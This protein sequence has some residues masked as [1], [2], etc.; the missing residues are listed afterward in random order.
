MERMAVSRTQFLK[1]TLLPGILPRIWRVFATGFTQVPYFIAVIYQ[2]VGILPRGHAYLDPRNVG[3]YGIRHVIAEAANHLV[4]DRKH[5]DQVFIFFI[6]LVGAVLLF[7]QLILLITAVIAYQPV[8]AAAPAL[9]DLTGELIF[10]SGPSA[11][12]SGPK[13]DLAFIFLDRVF[14]IKG[15]FNSCVDP[16]NGFCKSLS[17][18]DLAVFGTFPS[19]FHKALHALLRFYSIGIFSIASFLIIYFIIAI[20]GETAAAGRAF[21]PPQRFNRVWA[22]V[23]LILCFA[24]LI[25]LESCEKSPTTVGLNGAQYITLESAKLGSNFATNGWNYFTL[26]LTQTH[27]GDAGKLI[28]TPNTPKVNNLLKFMFLTRVCKSAENFAYSGPFETPNHGPDGIQAYIVSGNQ[29]M[30]LATGVSFSAARTFSKNGNIFIRFGV[31]NAQMY[32]SEN[33]NV[34]PLCGEIVVPVTKIDALGAPTSGAS[35]IQELYFQMVRDLWEKDDEMGKYANCMRGRNSQIIPNP[36]CTEIPDQAFMNRRITYYQAKLDKDIKDAI[37]KQVAAGGWNIDP[38]MM[39]KGW[40]GAG[41]WYNRIAELNGD[42]SSSVYSIPVSSKYP[43]IMEYVAQQRQKNNQ[44]VSVSTIYTP[45]LAQGREITPPR[46]AKDLEIAAILNKTYLLW[47]V[48]NPQAG[49]DPEENYGSFIDTVNTIFGTSGLFSMRKNTDIH[50]LAQ[51][52]VLGK[53]MMYASI[54]NFTGGKML[55]EIGVILDKDGPGRALGEM[56]GSFFVTMGMATMA[57]SFVL[58]Y[59]IPFMPF[60]YFIF[61]VGAWVK[62]IFEAMV[63]M[64]LW[65]L[66]HIRIDGEGMPGQAATQG[67]FLILEI[68]LRPILIV[69]GLLASI[70]VFSAL[71]A[72]MN[73]IF[74]L[75]TA[76]LGGF[77]K[78]SEEAAIGISMV[79]YARNPLDQFFFTAIYVIL[80]Y[81]LGLG[82]FKLVDNIP[83]AITRWLGVAISPMADKTGDIEGKFVGDLYQG[84]TMA[85][86]KLSGGQLAAILANRR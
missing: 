15:F 25:P 27:L 31:K 74:L 21:G 9:P 72:V 1:Y 75:V 29:A 48:T 50:P 84:A 86:Q 44:N 61:A 36:Y 11:Y 79:N 62:A 43:Y 55:E 69:F 37:A 42:I 38:N 76:N 6:I 20:T 80:C 47:R 56:I 49:D 73:E 8:F 18:K 33:G 17:D 52:S 71:V 23:R 19:P 10:G 81:M 67:Y 2:T 24:L 70:Q 16:A 5:A 85:T 60:I 40:A 59:V 41:I 7:L 64:P 30:L 65:A 12:N 3:R 45:T 68:F 82:C 83:D 13:Q 22:P 63:G 78:A 14:G 32:K 58:Y 77:D 34:A 46:T 26:S 57:M 39:A 4:F 35:M 51:L 66:A 53:G 54:R 28:G